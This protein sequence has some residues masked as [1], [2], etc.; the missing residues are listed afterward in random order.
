MKSKRN[1]HTIVLE[2]TDHPDFERREVYQFTNS[3]DIFTVIKKGNLTRWF[4]G[5]ANYNQFNSTLIL[6][7]KKILYNYEITTY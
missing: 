4:K 7:L 6:T 3:R 5:N 2:N 1:R